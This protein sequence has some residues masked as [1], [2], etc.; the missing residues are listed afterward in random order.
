MPIYYLGTSYLVGGGPRLLG[1]AEQ[2]HA[3]AETCENLHL[4]D[5]RAAATSGAAFSSSEICRRSDMP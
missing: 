3:L 5:V 4:P 2:T 1:T